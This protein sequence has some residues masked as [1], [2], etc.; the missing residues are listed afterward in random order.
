MSWIYRPGKIDADND[1]LVYVVGYF[2]P[3][4]GFEGIAD[5]PDEMQAMWRVHFLNGGSATPIPE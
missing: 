3:D 2:S 4:G 1:D 5:F